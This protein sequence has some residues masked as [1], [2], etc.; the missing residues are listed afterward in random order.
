MGEQTQKNSL[1]VLC[2]CGFASR[3]TLSPGEP[4]FFLWNVGGGDSKTL[5]I[6]NT[7]ELGI[8]ETDNW[9]NFRLNPKYMSTICRSCDTVAVEYCDFFSVEREKCETERVRRSTTPAP[10]GSSHRR[11]RGG[12]AFDTVTTCVM[13]GG[14]QQCRRRCSKFTD[15]TTDVKQRLFCEDWDRWEVLCGTILLQVLGCWR[16]GSR[17]G[18]CPVFE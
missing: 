11:R 9:Q 17:Q 2:T 6:T 10:A 8:S 12:A 7:A 1:W 3:C 15:E 18:D 14:G 13:E 4:N 16:D 5:V